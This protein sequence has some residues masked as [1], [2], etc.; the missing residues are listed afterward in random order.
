MAICTRWHWNLQWSG[1]MIAMK[2]CHKNRMEFDN[3]GQQWC[4]IGG[5]RQIFAKSNPDYCFLATMSSASTRSMSRASLWGNSCK[6][7]VAPSTYSLASCLVREIP[8]GL[9]TNSRAWK[10]LHVKV[11]RRNDPVLYLFHIPWRLKLTPNYWGDDVTIYQLVITTSFHFSLLSLIARHITIVTPESTIQSY[12]YINT[13]TLFTRTQSSTL[14]PRCVISCSDL[15][16]YLLSLRHS[17]L[18]DLSIIIISSL[19]QRSLLPCC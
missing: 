15:F 3:K 12:Q 8:D 17:V 7:F 14:G 4:W 19:S 10:S 16:T 6:T 9:K 11:R 1:L 5:M 2:R 13:V 18:G